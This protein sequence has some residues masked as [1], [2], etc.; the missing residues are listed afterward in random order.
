MSRGKCPT[1]I[2]LKLDRESVAE[3]N[4]LK[5]KTELSKVLGSAISFSMVVKMFSSRNVPTVAV[6]IVKNDWELFAESMASIPKIHR[7]EVKRT[8]EL[9][10]LRLYKDQKQQNFWEGIRNGCSF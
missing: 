10:I 8:A 4:K 7:A 5:A 6:N 9:Q 3:I 1:I 2:G